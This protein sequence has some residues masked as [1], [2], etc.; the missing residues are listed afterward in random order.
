MNLQP[1]LENE[2][3]LLRPLLSTDFDAL[4]AAAADEKIWEQHPNKNRYQLKDFTIY[5]EGAILSKGAFVIIDKATNKFMGCTRYY[6][7]DAT[8]KTVFIGYTFITTA[9]WGKAYNKQIKNLMINY[10]FDF[11]YKIL[12]HVGANNLRSQKAVGRIGGKKIK[13][14]EVAYHG[15]TKETN[16]EYC[17]EKVDW[18]GL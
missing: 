18:A 4:F 14:V 9:Y 17:I 3:V 12:F 1:I 10:A 16:F 7:Y 13:E 5:F 11:V 6:D 2:N 8:Q 15:E